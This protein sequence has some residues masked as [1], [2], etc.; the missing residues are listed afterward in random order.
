M[1]TIRQA[2][3]D[4]MRIQFAQALAATVAAHLGKLARAGGGPLDEAVARGVKLAEQVGV[5]GQAEIERLLD[6][7]WTPEHGIPEALPRPALAIL[8]ASGDP[9]LAKLEKIESWADAGKPAGSAP[10]ARMPRSQVPVRDRALVQPCPLEQHHWIEIEM[11][12]EIDEPVPW[13]EYVVVLPDAT[14]VSGYLDGQGFARISGFAQAG[15]CQVQFPELDKDAW[16]PI[17]SRAASTEGL[18]GD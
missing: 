2:Q 15:T 13:L 8:L 10:P 6:V 17:D 7:F 3:I 11:L 9:P 16:Q 5:T 14:K 18:S 12:D 1:L 4:S